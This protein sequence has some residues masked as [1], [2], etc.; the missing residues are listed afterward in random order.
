MA[1]RKDWGLFTSR[2]T[3]WFI[4]NLIV[5]HAPSEREELKAALDDIATGSYEAGYASGRKEAESESDDKIAAER[6]AAYEEGRDAGY[7]AGYAAHE[8]E[9]GGNDD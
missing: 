5:E 8:S 6:D 4:L 3:D 2:K 1:E 9:V 7:D